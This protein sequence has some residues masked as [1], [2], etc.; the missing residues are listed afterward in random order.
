LVALYATFLQAMPSKEEIAKAEPLVQEVMKS[1][2]EA[3]RLNK[4]TRAQVGAAAVALAK[5]AQAPAEKYL[6]LTGAFDQYL[7]GGAYDE[8]LASLD[9]LKRAIPDFSEKDEYALLEKAVRS[10]SS[11]KGD[12]LRERHAALGKRINNRTRLEKL[13]AQAKKTPNDKPLHFRIATYQVYFDDWPSALD[14]F[15]LSDNAACIAAAQAEKDPSSPKSKIADLWWDSTPLKPDFLSSALRSHAV[16]LYKEALSD[17]T[18]T[19]LQKVV[20]ERRIKEHDA[21]PATASAS[22][23]QSFSQVSKRNPY[24]TKGLVA[25]WDGEWNAGLGRHVA[26]A[27][28]WKDLV[29]SFDAKLSQKARFEQKALSLEK[30]LAF[31]SFGGRLFEGDFTLELVIVGVPSSMYNSVFTASGGAW[32]IFIAGNSWFV[33]HNLGTSRPMLALAQFKPIV[34]ISQNGLFRIQYADSSVIGN[35]VAVTRGELNQPKEWYFGGFDAGHRFAG[36]FYAVRY[37]SRAL[38]PDEIASNYK[39]DQRRFDIK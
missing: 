16:D 17:T 18:F 1:E 24:V 39:I 21:E 15:I 8:A 20:A 2:M 3:L 35:A 36:K 37:Y 10:V 28:V 22:A 6:L 26:N 13:L 19:G 9:E 5:E 23:P 29:G 38:T 34:L 12:A 7:R 33:K 14:E 30:D 27:T 4:K 31:A 25:M 32:S 11:A